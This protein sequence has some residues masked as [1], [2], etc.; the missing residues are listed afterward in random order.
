ME[1]A[2]SISPLDAPPEGPASG[3]FVTAPPLPPRRQPPP[4]GVRRCAVDEAELA[5]FDDFEDDEDIDDEMEEDDFDYDDEDEFDDAFPDEDGDG[6]LA[7]YFDR[8]SGA[9]REPP[10]R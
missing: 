4:L 1:T 3:R 10:S 6:G 7:D 8:V 2:T 9:G 5:D